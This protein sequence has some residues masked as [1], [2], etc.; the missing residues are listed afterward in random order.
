MALAGKLKAP[1]SSFAVL[2]FN[3]LSENLFRYRAM[4]LSFPS[5]MAWYATSAQTP[6]QSMELPLDYYSN[7]KGDL[8]SRI[9]NDVVEIEFASWP[10]LK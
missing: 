7:E 5:G 1:S 2:V 4:F 3:D 8:M 9:T 10:A 6:P